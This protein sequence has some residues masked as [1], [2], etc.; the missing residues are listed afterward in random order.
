VTLAIMRASASRS[1]SERS[2]DDFDVIAAAWIYRDTEPDGSIRS[3][4]RNRLAM[5][6]DL[7]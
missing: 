1:S 7:L 6:F 3:F 4:Q 2:D 5:I